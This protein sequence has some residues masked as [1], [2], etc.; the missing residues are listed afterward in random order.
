MPIADLKITIDGDGGLSGFL[1]LIED[2]LKVVDLPL[3]FRD[4]FD[5]IFRLEIDARATSVSEIA[6]RLNPSDRLVSLVAALL[7]TKKT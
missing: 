2:L 1:S 3:E 7:E 5:E 6:V 4:D